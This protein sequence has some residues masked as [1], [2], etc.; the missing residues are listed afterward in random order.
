MMTN[1]DKGF[2]DENANLVD[3]REEAKIGMTAIDGFDFERA[4]QLMS[5]IEKCA[6]VGVKATSIAGIAQT[7]L[8]EMNE[9]AKDIAKQRAKEFAE[10]EAIAAQ[11]LAEQR[12][13]RVAEAEAKATQAAE[14]ADVKARAI[15]AADFKQPQPSPIAGSRTASIA[16]NNARRV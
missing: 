3:D 15:P 4:I 12:Q 8:N 14:A 2:V 5:V 7:A 6:N 16:D 1:E 11:K 13:E 9:E 10:A